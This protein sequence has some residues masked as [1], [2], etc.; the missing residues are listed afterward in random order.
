MKRFLKRLWNAFWNVVTTIVKAVIIG[1]VISIPTIF[2]CKG[3]E[4]LTGSTSITLGILGLTVFIGL[5][6]F[7]FICD[8]PDDDNK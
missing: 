8:I 3:I 5:V 6:V 4:Y 1:M 7:F 2:L